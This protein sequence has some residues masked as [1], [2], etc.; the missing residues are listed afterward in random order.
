MPSNYGLF[1]RYMKTKN[2]ERL[3]EENRRRR[4]DNEAG[5]NKSSSNT[6]PHTEL[7]AASQ[8]SNDLS[9]LVASIKR[10]NKTQQ[11]SQGRGKRQKET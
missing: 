1:G 9:S 4:K 10:K 5:T 11:S 6:N 3:L 2:M 8:T 7:S